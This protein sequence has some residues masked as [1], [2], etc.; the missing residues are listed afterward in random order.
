M[1]MTGSSPCKFLNEHTQ[2][3]PNV[4]KDLSSSIT[5]CMVPKQV[6]DVEHEEPGSA[7]SP[8]PTMGGG[9]GKNSYVR[10]S[11]G[12]ADFMERM[13][14]TVLKPVDEMKILEKDTD[15]VRVVDFGCSSG[16]NTI[17]NVE[18]IL[19]RMKRNLSDGECPEFQA[20]FQD[21]HETDFNTLFRFFKTVSA[22]SGDNGSDDLK[23]FAVGAP[24]SCYG[25]IFPKSSVHFAMSTF[26]LHWLS[27]IPPVIYDQND[28]AYFGAHN[29]LVFASKA[30]IAA[31]AE[32]AN[33]DLRNF[34]D[35]RATEMVPGGVMT[36]VFGV[37]KTYYPYSIGP[38]DMTGEK[39]WD[40]MISEGI[41]DAKLKE[42]FKSYMYFR[43]LK[44]V[45]EVLDSFSSMFKTEQR[46]V[47]PFFTYPPGLTAREQGARFVSLQRGIN[48]TVFEAHF[49]KEATNI[50]WER[51]E[52]E[53]VRGFSDGTITDDEE[54]YYLILVVVATRR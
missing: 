31:Y 7:N 3:M 25:R 12:Q 8:L 42:S 4:F 45:E 33:I 54:N 26:A 6:Q 1:D 38:T 30:T 9:L 53:L 52:E 36:L 10:N 46:H 18:T 2:S 16:P 27:R 40:E 37:R 22:N 43:Y 24:G 44:D 13:F 19:R 11:N 5:T 47:S 20:F 29:E 35:A 28:E 15:V 39:V 17:R 48:S 34:L 41:V 21:L 50:F 14:P 51:Y 32:Q 23:Y 49:G